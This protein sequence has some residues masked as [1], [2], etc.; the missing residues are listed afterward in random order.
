MQQTYLYCTKCNAQLTDY[1]VGH[2]IGCDQVFDLK[3]RK[4]SFEEDEIYFCEHCKEYIPTQF[5]KNHNL[6]Y[7]K[8]YDYDE[9]HY[10]L[11]EYFRRLQEQESTPEVQEEIMIK[12]KQTPLN[13]TVFNQLPQ[14]K[15][16]HNENF[17]EENKKCSVCQEHFQLND[18]LT[19]LPC[20]HRY[21]TECI[22]TWLLEQT[23]FCPICRTKIFQE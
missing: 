12:I 22:K 9:F 17:D 10:Q 23:D 15:Y 8:L 1:Y 3:P 20:T 7:H 13:G 5:K 16:V 4:K 21:H 2:E 19:L 14:I 6:A 18:K 11:M